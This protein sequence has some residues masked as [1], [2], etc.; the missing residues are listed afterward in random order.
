VP[1]LSSG[2]RP[3]FLAATLAAIF[4][5]PAWLVVLSTGAT[6]GYWSGMNFHAHEMIFGYTAAVVAGFLLTAASN[7]TKTSVA[8]GTPLLLLVLLWLLGRVFPLSSTLPPALTAS[9]D[10]LFLPAVGVFVG[11][12]MVRTTNRRNYFF[13]LL[14]VLLSCANVLFHLEAQG[15]SVPLGLGRDLA[16][17]VLAFMILVMA[18][19]V[20]PMFTR[21]ATGGS[22]M[23]RNSLLLDR[24]ALGSFLVAAVAEFTPLVA[25]AQAILWLVSGVANTVRMSTWG[26]SR[27]RAPLL[28]ILHAG[29]FAIALSMLLQAGFLLGFVP[30]ASALHCFTVGGIGLLTLGMMA[31]VSLGHSGRMLVAPRSVAVSFALLT[32]AALVRVVFPLAFPSQLIFSWHLSGGLWTASFLLFLVFGSVVWFSPRADS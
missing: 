29:Y 21:N 15:Y 30:F 28:W 5:V 26:V 23:I 14:L 32:I 3:F 24:L 7:W 16:L 22:A 20:F 12:A 25:W 27:A 4:L 2:F 17:R 1:I 18:G 11:R 10:L 8:T 13:V 31:R 19:R 6:G 9:V